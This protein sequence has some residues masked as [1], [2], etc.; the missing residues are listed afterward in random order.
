MYVVGISVEKRK[1]AI[2]EVQNVLTRFGDKITTRLGIHDDTNESKG[3]IIT[4]YKA[5]D[6][7]DFIEKLNSIDAVEASFMKI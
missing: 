5:D 3:I 1:E 2:P 7:G 4:T 6:I